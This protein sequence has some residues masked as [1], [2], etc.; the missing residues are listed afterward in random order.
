MEAAA[1]ATEAARLAVPFFCIR[2]VSDSARQTFSIDFN[3]AR[4]PDGTF[5]TPQIAARAALSP[6]G[7]RDLI[8][9]GRAAHHSAQAL[10]EFLGSCQ[11][12]C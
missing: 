4:R 11:F 12:D 5:S 8:R 2:T 6:A 7:W 9:M 1:V 3:Q 10:G